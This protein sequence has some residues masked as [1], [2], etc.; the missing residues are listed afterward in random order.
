VRAWPSEAANE[1]VVTLFKLKVVL[2]LLVGPLAAAGCAVS[3]PSTAPFTL[4]QLKKAEYIS[5]VTSGKRAQ[6][7]D[8]KFE[9]ELAPG[10]ASKLTIQLLDPFATGDLN[11]DGIPDAAV[12][13]ATNM[14]GSGVFVD[15]EAVLN[16]DGKP[17][18]AGLAR[19][20][21]RTQIKSISIDQGTIAVEM[22]T[23]GPSDPMCCPT[24]HITEKFKLQGNDLAQVQ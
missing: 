20:G 21:D 23:Q 14:G 19:L 24:L 16:V 11:G 12:V 5:P 10:A 2:T 8:G 22:V 18:S 6:L 9:D 17:S 4:E 15:L 1:G 7:V 3:T 13:L